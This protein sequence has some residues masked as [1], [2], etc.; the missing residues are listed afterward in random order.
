MSKPILVSDE[1]VNSYNIRILTAGGDL[2]RFQKNP[3]ML[4][5]H[6]RA[7]HGGKTDDILPLGTWIDLKVEGTKI[8]ATPKFDIEDEFA[9]KI[10][11]KFERG[12]IRSASIGI[13]P[14]KM[15]Q[16]G[17]DD[18]GRAIFWVTKWI[19]ME[20]SLVDIPSNENA[21]AFYDEN[22]QP[23]ELS[24]VIAKFSASTSKPKI[25]VPMKF[26]NVP[27]LLGL[28]AEAT[29]EQ[30][31]EKIKSLLALNA[32]LEKEV[33]NYKA[34]AEAA[35]K[36]EIED[37][38][39][40]AV[41]EGRMPEAEKDQY[42]K[43]LGLAF[44]ETKAII[45]GLPVRKQI[46]L[47]DV[48]R[49]KVIPFAKDGNKNDK[50]TFEGMTFSDMQKKCPDKLGTLKAENFEMFNDLYRAEYGKDYRV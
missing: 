47:S 36:K 40:L 34:Q 41:K 42:T 1:S 22:D 7:A 37:L 24:A 20:I 21:V 2:S 35:R 38:V 15:H 44:D 39:T 12:V 3:I 9:A 48:P 6:I 26:Q 11:G 45:E 32:K 14:L 46:K 23:I 13:I 10:A 8:Y 31:G 25:E 5:N 30:V 17:V 27:A 16:E 49:K 18:Q 33:G 43:L 4:L 28:T 50:I 29:D 19:L